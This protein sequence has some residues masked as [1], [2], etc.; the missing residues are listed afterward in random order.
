MDRKKGMTVRHFAIITTLVETF[1]KCFDPFTEIL[2]NL[3]YTNTRIASSSPRLLETKKGEV[4]VVGCVCEGG[5]G[6]G[7]RGKQNF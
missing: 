5:G 4:V 2:S 6:G 3:S 1:L 7:G